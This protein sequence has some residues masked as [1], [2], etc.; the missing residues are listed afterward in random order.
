MAFI[1]WLCDRYQVQHY[2]DPCKEK[3]NS[4]KTF[5]HTQRP[6]ILVAHV[7]T[8][9]LINK[10]VTSSSSSSSSN[11]VVPFCLSPDQGD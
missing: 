8:L 11:N 2:Q 7:V 10:T 5:L 6:V 3:E 4:K 1:K 9:F